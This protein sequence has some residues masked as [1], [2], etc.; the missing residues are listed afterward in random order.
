MK[1]FPYIL[2]RVAGGPFEK[3][4]ALE[5]VKS[6]KIT[7]EIIDTNKIITSIQQKLINSLFEVVSKCSDQKV[8]QSLI[9]CKRDIYNNR[10][11]P[12]IAYNDISGFLPKEV[13]DDLTMHMKMVD[14][15]SQLIN[16]GEIK[17]SFELT[18]NRNILREL[19][20]EEVLQKGLILSSQSLLKFGVP[21]YL[22]INPVMLNKEEL[23]AERN[24]LKYVTRIYAKT[25]PFSTFTNLA[26]CNI[27]G[28]PATKTSK[29]QTCA[30]EHE[31]TYLS[32]SSHI[33]LNNDL[34]RY[35][36]DLL[37]KI[38]EINHHFLICLNPTLKL[39][40]NNYVFLMNLHNVESFQRIEVNPVLKLLTEVI[41]SNKEGLVYEKLINLL[42]DNQYFNATRDDIEAYIN[43]LLD[44]GFFEFNIN[45]SGQDPDWDVHL[46]EELCYL[47]IDS[48][49]IDEL[50]MSLRRI[51]ELT[52]QYKDANV[53]GRL[54]ILDEAFSRINSISLSLKNLVS[55]IKD[56]D[57]T[58]SPTKS[59]KDEGKISTNTHANDQTF[60]YQGSPKFHF[61]RGNIFYED[62]TINFIPEF[63]VIQLKRLVTSLYK[64][65]RLTKRFE[66][67]LDERN[68]MFHYFCKKYGMNGPVDLLTFYE[69][70]YR[71]FKIPLSELEK[72][73]K[74]KELSKRKT[75]KNSNNGG[76]NQ[77]ISDISILNERHVSDQEWL[78]RF[79][80]IVN[81]N[82]ENNENQEK[83]LFLKQFEKANEMVPSNQRADSRTSEDI[84]IQLFN[85]KQPTGKEKLIGVM[86]G[87]FAGFGK[88]MSRFLYLFD[89]EV[90]QELRSTILSLNQNDI[91][92]EDC[93]S[94][95]FN[96]NLHPPLMPFEVKLPNGQNILPF[97]KQIP[98]TELQVTIAKD[99]NRLQLIHMPSGKRTYCF[100]VALMSTDYRSQLFQLLETFTLAEILNWWVFYFPRNQP[101]SHFIENQKK[102]VV[103]PRITYEGQIIL[104]RKMWIVPKELIPSKKTDDSD[105][106]YFIR[107][108]EWRI[109]LGI[110]EEVFI[111]ITDMRKVTTPLK[112][113]KF[114]SPDDHKPQYISF[115]SPLL[116]I[117]FEK[118]VPRVLTVLTIVEMLPT[119]RNLLKINNKRYVTEFVIEWF[120]QT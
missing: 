3:L 119:S 112:N 81:E 50:L 108:N 62:T 30:A 92:M 42:L 111:Y 53:N 68:K 15:V 77:F 20:K 107:L 79:A 104:S 39:E 38:P 95:V 66:S 14:K 33:R 114:I 1:L 80:A 11:I 70:Y 44:Y 100:D 21:R 6:V 31:N 64:L 109:D 91:F 103:I 117:L 65:S 113:G 5:A 82:A 76:E 60:H 35:I 9:E 102:I 24:I 49:V 28:K 10:V 101:Y 106:S 57:S 19:C 16:E 12:P 116:V 83:H 69:D 72:K 55:D 105:W 120:T 45:I 8:R 58:N 115:D 90:N 78:E 67:H 17:Y 88:M 110:P 94:A 32:V 63:D 51:R 34:W 7:R 54:Q 47:S 36:K 74:D 98:I 73:H 118:S 37:I 23:Q 75:K 56:E 25:S 43:Q 40:G 87:R 86:N 52:D 27:S 26:I 71:E 41:T 22:R 48:P 61:T 97:D 84:F 18:K 99:E 96:A 13:Y 93:D 85:E 2:I 89:D 29:K 59:N 4:E 46:Q